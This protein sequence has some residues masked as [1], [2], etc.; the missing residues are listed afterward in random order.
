MGTDDQSI[1]VKQTL[2]CVRDEEGRSRAPFKEIR[3]AH[4]ALFGGGA[5]DGEASGVGVRSPY[6]AKSSALP[7]LPHTHTPTHTHTHPHKA[8]RHTTPTAKLSQ[9]RTTTKQTDQKSLSLSLC[10][11]NQKSA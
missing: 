7:P 6:K 9:R 5:L 10:P 3:G 2:H 4:L 8:N 11:P 1:D